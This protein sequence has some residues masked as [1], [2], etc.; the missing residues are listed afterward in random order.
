MA[1]FILPNIKLPKKARENISKEYSRLIRES[2]D[3]RDRR[4]RD[5]W[6]LALKNYE[7]KAEPVDFPWPNA[8]NAVVSLTP[9]HAD[10]W[11]SR[12]KN[13]GTAQD[14]VYL[15]SAWGPGD[16]TP[17]ID[18]EDY[19][20]TYQQWSK[21]AEVEEIPNDPMVEKITTLTTKYGNAIAYVT[22]EHEEIADITY[23]DQGN[24]VTDV[25]GNVP[26]IDL[27][28]KPVVHVLHPKNFY[29]NPEEEDPQ[30]APWC[31]ID[32]YYT[33]D[34]VRGLIKNGEWD[35]DAGERVLKFHKEQTEEERK[36]A[37]GRKAASYYRRREDGSFITPTEWDQELKRT[38]EMPQ[39][40]SRGDIEFQRVFARI[41]T[42]EDGILE[43]VEMLIH[44]ESRNMVSLKHSKYAHKKRPLVLFSFQ[45]REGT[46]MAMGVPEMLFNSQ[47]IMNEIMRD[48]LNNNKVRNTKMIAGKAGS[49]INPDEPVFPGRIIMMD[50]PQSDIVAIDLSSGAPATSLQ[51]MSVVQAWAERRDGITE[52]NLGRERTSRTPATTVLALL[53]EGNERVVSI[54]RNQKLGQTEIWT[55]IHQLYAQHGDADGLDRVIGEENANRLRDAWASMDVTDIRKKLILRAQVST[56][57]LNRA[58]KRQET[59]ALM[60]QLDA[61]HQRVIQL[62]NVVRTTPDPVIRALAISMLKSGEFL[63]K[64]ILNTHDIKDHADMNPALSEALKQ[65]PPGPPIPE[66]GNRG[67]AAQVDQAGAQGPAD[68]VNAPGRPAAGL[69]RTEEGG[70]AQ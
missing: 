50:N 33:P 18:A 65:L 39:I 60:G 19:A 12:L 41:D 21:W 55:Q 10:A 8:A 22:W 58:I 62:A 44:S 34:D 64:R 2:K 5:V 25:D 37:G 51:D 16:L 54:V 26:T 57:N 70:T 20:E 14:P 45:W 17:E 68:P 23:D 40:T 27:L 67:A 30:L 49:V 47:R 38:L 52:A 24:I 42:D 3:D 11:K 31:A 15:T 59:A 9:S 32:E 6:A 4:M 43:E 63:M 53:E 35:K 46:W 69:P 61:F 48:M 66:G 56:Q 7:G 1:S 29:M 13:A 36:R 28:N